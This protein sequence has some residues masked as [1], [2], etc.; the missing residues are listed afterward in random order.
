MFSSNQG[1][2]IYVQQQPG[3]SNICS[4][5]TSV[6]KYMFSSNQGVQIYVQQQPV[7][8]NICLEATG[9]VCLLALVVYYLQKWDA[10]NE[11]KSKKKKYIFVFAF[12]LQ[13]LLR[14]VLQDLNFVIKKVPNCPT[15]NLYNKT[16]HKICCLQPAKRLDQMGGNFLW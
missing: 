5:A 14:R 4:V 11:F 8:S 9:R 1:V 2:Q 12:S 7:C 10:L 3:C 13:K 6:F 16:R 15:L